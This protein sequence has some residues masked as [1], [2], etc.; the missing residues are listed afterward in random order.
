MHC[1]D[2]LFRGR[3]IKEE[4]ACK[5]AILS[6]ELKLTNNNHGETFLGSLSLFGNSLER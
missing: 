4:S 5:G 2:N 3:D 6:N 1:E